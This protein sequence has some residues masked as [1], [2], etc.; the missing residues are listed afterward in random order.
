M[1]VAAPKR[2]RRE[3]LVIDSSDED[4]EVAAAV[5]ARGSVYG[6]CTS[7]RRLEAGC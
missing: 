2:R 5:E 7:L 3:R 6:L 1:S 4:A